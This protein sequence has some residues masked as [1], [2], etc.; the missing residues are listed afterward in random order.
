MKITSSTL[1]MILNKI[2]LVYINIS[3]IYNYMLYI[4]D[5]NDRKLGMLV[6]CSGVHLLN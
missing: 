5:R 6:H 1:I 3:Y 2:T 4:Y